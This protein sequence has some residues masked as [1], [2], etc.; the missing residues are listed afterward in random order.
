MAML[1]LLFSA[2][3]F[4][5]VATFVAVVVDS[6]QKRKACR[7]YSTIST[8]LK[9]MVLSLCLTSTV[10]AAG[11]GNS[12]N[13]SSYTTGNNSP[14]GKAVTAIGKE[15][16]KQAIQLL[17]DYVKQAPDNAH[18]WNYLGFSYRKTGQ[19]E[20]AKDAYF[21]ALSIDPE[22]KGANEY[23]GELYVETGQ[24]DKARERL[25]KLDD[26][27]FFSCKEYDDLKAMIDAKAL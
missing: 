6:L 12:G 21:K 19:Y 24:L 7:K 20:A 14:F 5:V 27:C 4:S 3:I 10:L 18:A 13:D 11:G 15:N 16:Y 23:L 22:H 8:V 2:Y 17:T 1:K 25:E 9:I 26:I